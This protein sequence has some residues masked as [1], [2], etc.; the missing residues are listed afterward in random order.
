MMKAGTT[1]TTG[2]PLKASQKDNKAGAKKETK[3]STK[4]T[5]TKK[6]KPA[7]SIAKTAVNEK[8][9][10]SEE[11]QEFSKSTELR[12]DVTKLFLVINV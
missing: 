6:E 3:P 5:L 12:F 7:E 10:N 1:K 4:T 11:S 8:P 9:K 2:M